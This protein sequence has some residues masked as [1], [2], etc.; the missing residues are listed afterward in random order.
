MSPIDL[1]NPLEP[2]DGL[3]AVVALRRLADQLEDSQVEQAMRDG[4]SWS[5]VAEALGVTRQAVHKKHVKRLVA[6]GVPLR[7]R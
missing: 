6:A 1:S 4:W 2:V 5:D 7:R 3:A